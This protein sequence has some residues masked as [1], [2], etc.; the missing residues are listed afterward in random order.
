MNYLLD[1][2]TCIRYINGR[3]PQIREVL[4]RI[5]DTDIAIS[6][7]TKGETPV[8][9]EARPAAFACHTG[10]LFCPLCQPAFR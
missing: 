7:V 9:P 1:T 4:G 3:G 10:C 2:N 6:T 5:V 8:Q